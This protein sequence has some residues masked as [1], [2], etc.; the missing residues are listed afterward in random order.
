MDDEPVAF[1][2]PSN[3]ALASLEALETNTNSF[4]VV[5]RSAPRMESKT[6]GWV[7]SVE[8]VQSH[9]RSYFRE[10]SRLI[11]FISKQSEISSLPYSQRISLF[12]SPRIKILKRFFM[13]L[14]RVK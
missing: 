7:G 10:F 8:H 11:D 6:G 2:Q 12:F 13:L 9:V 14:R 4:V 5:I 1:D 3:Y